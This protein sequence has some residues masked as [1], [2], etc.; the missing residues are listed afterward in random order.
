VDGKT[1]QAPN[2]PDVYEEYQAWPRETLLLVGAR[3]RFQTLP[4]AGMRDRSE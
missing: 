4:G 3:G 2:I 1:A